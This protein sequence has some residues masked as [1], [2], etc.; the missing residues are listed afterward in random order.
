MNTN[1]RLSSTEIAALWSVY[2]QE[3]ASRCFLKYFLNTVQDEE[4]TSVIQL[5]LDEVESHLEKIT[6]I[7]KK[8]DFPV[9]TGFSDND[10]DLTAPPLFYDLFALSY[11]YGNARIG[12][13]GIGK[14]TS[15]IA[16]EDVLDLFSNLLTRTNKL[17]KKS[18]N[19]MLSK[20]IYDRPPKIPYPDK[21][22]FVD[23]QSFLTGWLGKRRPLNVIELTE[24]FFN[25]ERNY[26]GILS[27][28]GFIQV[29]K[30]KEVKEYFKRGKDLAEKQ[31]TMF[32]DI[33]KEDDLLGTIPVSMEVTNSTTAPFSDKLMLYMITSLNATAIG[34]MGFS[35][36]SAMRRD[37]GT[38][39]SRIMLNIIKY[40][41]D[42]ANLMIEK[43]WMEQPPQAPDRNAPKAG[44]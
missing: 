17:Y 39:Y 7:F 21:V 26:F 25:I 43:S 33:L 28:T 5:A 10:I 2:M 22:E 44:N 14:M 40:S 13:L 37:L 35:I 23:D 30:D 38:H 12:L 34:F 29:V 19:L 11:V 41:E 32:N 18:V 4:I 16:R 1:E 42:G 8:E 27:L 15:N 3:S 31:T 20:G 24:L 9:P 6:N 36:G